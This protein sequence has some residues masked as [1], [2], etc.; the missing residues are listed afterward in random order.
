MAIFSLFTIYWQSQYYHHDPPFPHRT[1]SRVAQH[2]P[3]FLSFR[4][5][6]ITGSLMIVLGWLTNT[7]VLRTIA[8]EEGINLNK[9]HFHIPLIAGSMGGMFLMMSTALIDTGIM[10]E[11]AH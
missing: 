10:N 4:L 2:Y 6:T 5:G 1:I 8:L 9:Y 3:E 11:K 7:F